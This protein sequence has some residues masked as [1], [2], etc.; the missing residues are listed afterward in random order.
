[1]SFGTCG[2]LA[3]LHGG[4]NVVWW[5]MVWLREREREREREIQAPKVLVLKVTKL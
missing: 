1:M 5:M 4:R 2:R 3:A